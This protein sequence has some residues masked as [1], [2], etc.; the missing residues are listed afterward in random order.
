MYRILSKTDILL[1]LIKQMGFKHSLKIL[2][3]QFLIA[4]D[5]NIF[6]VFMRCPVCFE[7]KK[8]FKTTCQ[9]IVTD[10]YVMILFKKRCFTA[11]CQYYVLKKNLS[12]QG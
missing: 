11:S 5:I 10:Q 2:Q 9:C 12:F 1:L 3:E 7:D 8:K 6:S 4:Y